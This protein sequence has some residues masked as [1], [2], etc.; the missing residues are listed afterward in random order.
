[1]LAC[2]YDEREISSKTLFTMRRVL[3]TTISQRILLLAAV[4]VSLCPFTQAQWLY[5]QRGVG[6][7]VKDLGLVVRDHEDCLVV[8]AR[9][10]QLINLETDY[11][12]PDL[13]AFDPEEWVLV[14]FG[15]DKRLRWFH[16]VGG[17]DVPAFTRLAA[18]RT[19][20]IHAA[21]FIE[22]AARL[23]TGPT[24]T[25][26]VSRGQR[27][28]CLARFAS[29]GSLLSVR[30]WGGPD[31]EL[32][33]SLTVT[34]DGGL[35]LAGAFKGTFTLSLPE[36]EI[37]LHAP[38][39]MQ[40]GFVLRLDP[41]GIEQW[42][43]HASV[44]WQ[45]EPGTSASLLPLSV[46]ADPAGNCYVTSG[47]E[48]RLHLRAGGRSAALDSRGSW[49]IFLAKIDVNGAL[50]WARTAGGPGGDYGLWVLLAEEGTSFVTGRFG[51]HA[52]FGEGRHAV[53]LQATSS[54]DIFMACYDTDG[55]FLGAVRTGG[56]SHV[57]DHS[58][59]SVVMDELGNRYLVGAGGQPAQHLARPPKQ[60][61]S[62]RD[63]RAMGALNPP[64]RFQ[65]IARGHDNVIHIVLEGKREGVYV[66]EIST[67]LREWTPVSTHQ[68]T[69]GRIL[70]QD[71]I[72]AAHPIRFYRVR[73][74]VAP[75][76]N[77][78]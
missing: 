58:A 60:F 72:D 15:A 8:L 73:Q 42:V 43:L 62:D 7:G 44:E 14:K 26:L 33:E 13:T 18:D 4:A 10:R 21:G 12:H 31:D 35:V 23:G 70:I 69:D 54:A 66:I 77:P 61:T 29:D 74:P 32:A 40:D 38:G 11:E 78:P 49:D 68:I 5:T 52:E 30:Q 2:N 50:Q 16:G 65:S 20:I 39:P 27:D 64:S 56:D 76:T 55:E 28:I 3:S 53:R 36:G 45:Q 57:V 41:Q 63:S 75:P 59:W 19:G 6:Y 37:Q 48:P 67:D 34:D 71:R 46:G 22:G 24:T 1:M 51:N 25:S 47:F 9:S 17:P